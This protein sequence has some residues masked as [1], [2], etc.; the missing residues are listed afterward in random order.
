MKKIFVLLLVCFM[1]VGCSKPSEE[2]GVSNTETET[3]ES[4]TDVSNTEAETKREAD[5]KEEAEDLGGEEEVVEKCEPGKIPQY[6]Q[7]IYQNYKELQVTYDFKYLV[8]DT[9]GLVILEDDGDISRYYFSLVDKEGSGGTIEFSF[10]ENSETNNIKKSYSVEFIP[11]GGQYLKDMITATFMITG[12]LEYLEAEEKMQKLI[13]SYCDGEMSALIQSGNY[14][15]YM[16][17]WSEDSEWVL[18][19]IVYHK[20]IFKPINKE[21][22]SPVDYDM[23]IDPVMNDGAKVVLV[24]KVIDI[25]KVKKNYDYYIYMKVAG[26]DG[27]EYLTFH[28]L[29]ARPVMFDI[30]SEYTFYGSIKDRGG[31]SV[32]WLDD[33]E[34][35]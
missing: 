28:S 32:I 3:E 35:K 2:T 7:K 10:R 30:G 20:E 5:M 27:N 1:F 34:Q 6:V 19:S 8:D 16:T 21:E 23:Y 12:G 24:G 15:S 14:T 31:K 13:S 25:S 26:M 17:P 22:Y 33:Y 18:F 11:G 9:R 4:G 29:C